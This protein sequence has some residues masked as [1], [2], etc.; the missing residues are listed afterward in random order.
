MNRLESITNKIASLLIVRAIRGGLVMAIPVLMIGS[1]ALVL[2][3]LPISFYQ[4][5]IKEYGG[6]FISN[7]FVFAY[8]GTFGF[9]SVYMTAC[10]SISYVQNDSKATEGRFG[11]PITAVICFCILS[12]V[13]SDGFEMDA[14]GAKGMFTAVLAAVSSNSVYNLFADHLL[15][16]VKLYVDGADA[17]FNNAFGVIAPAAGTVT[18]F[19]IFNQIIVSI[20]GVSGFNHLF[21][22]FADYIFHNLGISFG[23]GALF[24]LLLNGF[25]FFGVHGGD[26]LEGVT[27][28]LFVPAMDANAA[29]AAQGLAPT[30]IVSK[31]FLDVFSLMGGCGA[32]IC[33]LL[34]ILVFSKRQS[35][36]SLAR[37]A[38]LPMIFNINELMVFG[39]PIVFNPILLIPF[40]LVPFALFALAYGATYLGIIP[41]ATT[42]VTWTTPVILSGYVATG[43]VMGSVLQVFLLAVGTLIY[44]PF[45]RQYDRQMTRDMERSVS[46]LVKTLQTH[47]DN[48]SYVELTAL[49]GR[50]GSVAKTLVMDFKHAVLNNSFSIYYQPQFDINNKCIGAEALLRWFHPSCGLIYPPLVIKLAEESGMLAELERSIFELAARDMQDLK[51]HF[52]EDFKVGVNLTMQTLLSPDFEQFLM[53]LYIRSCFNRGNLLIEITEQMAVLFN[54]RTEAIFENLRKVGYTFGIDDFSMGH[55]S[56]KYLQKNYFSLVKLDGSLAKD[57]DN[58][59][60]REIISSIVKLSETLGFTVLSEV[61]ESE[62]QRQALES[63]GCFYYQGFLYSPAIPLAELLEMF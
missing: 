12:G 33:L 27:Q 37:S 59:R 23:A 51:Y 28:S 15:K 40:I 58:P 43:S 38:A 49:P 13:L 19:A 9:L 41:I 8:N 56:L 25:W 45:I 54:D 53:Q 34:A 2:N 16:P 29:A 6:G 21:N 39:L 32:T 11:P 61:V 48:G 44:R 35:T 36:R 3:T 18:I 17:E 24:L 30:E 31:T 60:S 46:E 62:E 20:F 47:E 10:I 7:I 55:T 1:F 50:T 14:F 4:T 5:L 63:V 42:E 52:G 57:I 22:E 26:V